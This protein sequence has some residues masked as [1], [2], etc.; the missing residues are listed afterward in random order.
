MSLEELML[1]TYMM[2]KHHKIWNEEHWIPIKGA[3]K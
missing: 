3:D 1:L 2:H